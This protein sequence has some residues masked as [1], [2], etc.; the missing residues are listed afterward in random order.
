MST[1]SS[2][3]VG[4]GL[5]LAG[6]LSKIMAVESL[7]LTQMSQQL[8]SYQAQVS[9][10]GTVLNYMSTLQT[11]AFNMA[12]ATKTDVYSATSSNT[13]VATATAATGAT[14]GTYNIN[15]TQLATAQTLSSTAFA[16]G[17][18]AV[19]GTGTLNI[20]GGG[21]NAFSV[22]VDS[23]NDTL[24]G[25]ASA[26]NS[27]SGNNGVQATVVT[28]TT[29]ARLVLTGLNTGSA[30]TI[31]VGVTENPSG[32]GLAQLS[33]TN[34][35]QVQAANNAAL[36]VNG[37]AISSASNSLSTV[38]T[39]VTVNLNQTGS[40]VIGVARDATGPTKVV[41]DFVNSYNALLSSINSQTAYDSTTK[42]AAALNGD[43][44]VRYAQQTLSNS[45]VNTPAG[46]TGAFQHLSDIGVS[47]QKDG[48]LSIDSTK[49]NNAI[50]TNFTDFKSF[51]SGFGQAYGTLV[52][53]LTSATGVINSH[54]SGL[55]T[56]ITSENNDI[57]A[58]QDRLTLI[59]A[60]Y[61][62]QF[63]ALDSLVSSM[64]ATSSYL[65]QQLAKL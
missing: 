46:V 47:V 9:G 5:D 6:M 17:S 56:S 18:S 41:T 28:D 13:A 20:S 34:L 36:T 55:N 57:T 61:Q 60:R 35:T 31:T 7:P 44:T 12:D 33:T 26:I 54:I 1:I 8:S 25:I 38:I 14:A 24:A 4:S 62:A 39:G 2:L 27:A 3:G 23:T 48:T 42:T 43:T 30:N 65:T 50:T 10:L 40:S 11:N 19:V 37:L 45:L 52:S 53:N 22:T 59:Q 16:S 49:L 21:G 63:T 32:S 15:V 64:N 29:G 51:V 58:F